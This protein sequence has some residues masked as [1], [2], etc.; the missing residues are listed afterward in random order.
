[1]MDADYMMH[2]TK[3]QRDKARDPVTRKRLARGAA[4]TRSARGTLYPISSWPSPRG[5]AAHLIVWRAKHAGPAIHIRD[6]E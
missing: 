3:G 2:R 1:M 4:E 6:L 5:I